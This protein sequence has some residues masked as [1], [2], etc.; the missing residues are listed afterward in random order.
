MILL[1]IITNRIK[2][3]IKFLTKGKLIQAMLKY[4]IIQ[5]GSKQS[6][7]KKKYKK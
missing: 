2:D 1:R 4:P 7:R 6:R 5:P 3:G